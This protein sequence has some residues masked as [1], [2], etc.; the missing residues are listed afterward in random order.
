M[1][2]FL[3]MYMSSDCNCILARPSELPQ[4]WDG[5]LRSTLNSDLSL[6]SRTPKYLAEFFDG[7]VRG[8]PRQKKVCVGTHRVAW[9]PF[10]L[11]ARRN[12]LLLHKPIE[13]PFILG[14]RQRQRREGFFALV[15]PPQ[16]RLDV[17][18]TPAKAL[19]GAIIT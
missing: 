12:N 13:E 4:S 8:G 18:A 10:A 9:L 17:S 2:P 11:I 6:P 15:F 19:T 1:Y 16:P 7:L 3:V 14:R 5:Q